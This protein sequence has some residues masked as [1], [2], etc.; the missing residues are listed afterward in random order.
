MRTQSVA[1]AEGGVGDEA[2]NVPGTGRVH[3][4]ALAAE[5]VVGVG[6]PHLLAAAGVVRCHVAVENARADTREDHT[7][8]VLGVHIG[9][10]LEDEGR[11]YRPLQGDCFIAGAA[12]NRFRG[13][14][15][16]PVE[17]ELH[18]EVVG[19]AAEED[20]R[21]AARQDLL[22]IKLP[23]GHIQHLDLFKDLFI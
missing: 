5:D 12:G 7:V 17:K 3:C 20:R 16:E 6:Y 23:L 10:D 11:E 8:P 13:V 19:G 9:L 2:D 18:A 21:G 15:Q 14:V 1:D 4:L 22:G